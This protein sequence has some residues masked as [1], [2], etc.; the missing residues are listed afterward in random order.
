MAKKRRT[1]ALFDVIHH[2]RRFKRAGPPIGSLSKAAPVATAAPAPPPPPTAPPEPR[3]EAR[4]AA[5][6]I[7]IIPDPETMELT[8]RLSYQNAAVIGFAVLTVLALA[9]AVGR[10]M[11]R[12]TAATVGASTDAVRNGPVH[13][14]VLHPDR[15]DPDGSLP[16]LSAVD[17]PVQAPDGHTPDDTAA[18][19]G[20]TT[21]PATP[22]ALAHGPQRVLNLNY[23]VIQSYP[24]EKQAA[25]A[26]AFLAE[27]GVQTTIERNLR[28]WGASWFV[29]V[30]TDGFAHISSPDYLAYRK[31]IEQLSLDF[32]N[33][34][35][36]SF[37]A[38]QPMPYRWDRVAQP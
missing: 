4:P 29:V 35:P 6:R 16:P 11:S 1:A 34:N 24:E 14:D 27:S 15:V 13:A 5:R 9:F 33:K 38:F 26:V 28:G 18:V 20:P 3:A 32:A 17:S 36:R 22:G 2:D 21:V 25:D 10:H 12:G 31:K 7:K 23:L 8:F 19:L 37:K 30:G